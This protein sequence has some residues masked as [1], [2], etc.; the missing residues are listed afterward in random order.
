MRTAP[1]LTPARLPGTTEH[2]QLQALLYYGNKDIRLEDWP[3]PEPRPGELKLRVA[4]CGICATDIE[5]WQ[6][7]PLYV[8]HDT[9]NPLSGRIAPIIMGHEITA[10][11]AETGPGV[12]GFQPG[13]RVAVQDV[14]PCG[15][16]YYC[17]RGMP[18]ACPVQ[19]I[20]GFSADGGLAEYMAWPA[21]LCVKLPDHVPSQEAALV[22]PAAVASHAVRRS[23]VRLGDRV[24]V[25]GVGTVGLL[26]LQTLKAAG[27][28]V[29]A[30][31]KKAKN[32]ALAAR[33][34]ADATIDVSAEDG[35]ER[36]LDLTDGIGPDMVFEVSGAPETPIQAI[37]WVRPW[38]KV[39]LVGIYTARPQF[40][41]HE[42]VGGEKEVVGSVSLEA[43]D[44]REAVRL[45]SDGKLQVR[46]LISDVVPLS[47]V[48]EDGFE[49]M[50]TPEEDLFRILI[51][52]GR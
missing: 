26:T 21:D 30:I 33:V 36:L 2:G 42:I 29:Y 51:E 13:D 40:Y 34:G 3:E 27:A 46:E 5:E 22:E 6:D 17:R 49:R 7:G 38:G 18:S 50:L 35:G 9:P 11:V 1:T 41:F 23:A 52:P 19:A 31:D 14:M 28:V 15:S 16:C 44:V 32:L 12:G 24:A 48:V 8:Q 37:Q 47:R 45:L 39:V 25:I 43:R 20:T 10:R 4:Y